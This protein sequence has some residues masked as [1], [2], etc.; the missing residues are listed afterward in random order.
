MT[1]LEPAFHFR[2]GTNDHE[3]FFSVNVGNDYMLPNVFQPDD[4]VIDIGMHIGSFCYAALTR[5]A[6]QVYGFE[7]DP[8]NFRCSL[9]NLAQFGGRIQAACQAVWRSDRPGDTLR[10]TRSDDSTNR[11]GAGVL[12]PN[13]SLGETV[14]SIA[15]DTLL[16]QVTD[17]GRRRVACLKIDCEGAE[18]P[19]LLT[20][21]QLH[22]VDSICGEFHEF[23]EAIPDHAR[24]T[25]YSHFTLAE[26]TRALNEQ[27]FTVHARRHEN[28]HLGFFFATN[29]ADRYLMA[30]LSSLR[31]LAELRPTPA[32]GLLARLRS[33]LG[34]S[35]L[36]PELAQLNQ[37][38]A[39]TVRVLE[40]LIARLERE[41]TA[42]K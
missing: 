35:L 4:I 20:S 16:L 38:H 2:D 6:G 36:A 3:I 28:S 13:R 23:G 8:E 32:A 42:G 9:G 33:R 14:S 10:L 37:T 18:F 34:W 12:H 17:G 29:S 39:A 31:G 26:L 19:I 30:Q 5:G 1:E 21:R 40:S 22:L 11:A 27:G 25:G 15:F 7:P 24:V 41:R